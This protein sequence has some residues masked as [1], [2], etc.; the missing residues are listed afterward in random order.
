MGLP[1]DS[2]L[3][4]KGETHPTYQKGVEVDRS[5]GYAIMPRGNRNYSV[6]Y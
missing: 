4:L 2:G 5:L 6:K 1:A 3:L